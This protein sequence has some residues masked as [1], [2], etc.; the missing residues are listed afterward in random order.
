MTTNEKIIVP[1]WEKFTLRSMD[2]TVDFFDS[3]GDSLGAVSMIVE[4]QQHFKVDI[5][6]EKFMRSPTLD[7]LLE[8]TGK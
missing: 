3:G 4:I 1:I 2:R 8:M 5:S 6:L 7:F